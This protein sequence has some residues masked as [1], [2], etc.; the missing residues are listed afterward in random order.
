MPQIFAF[1]KPQTD[2]ILQP[3]AIFQLLYYGED[4]EGIEDLPIQEIIAALKREFPQHDE[5]PGLLSVRGAV[6]HF[7]ATWTWQHFRVEIHDLVAADLQ[8]LIKTVQAFG[9]GVY[10]SQANSWTPPSQ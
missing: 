10:D 4:A 6:G 9:C 3:Q 5:Q 8:Q 1:W 7:D 2:L